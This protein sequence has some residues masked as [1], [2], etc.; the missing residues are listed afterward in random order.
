MERTLEHKAKCVVF[1]LNDTMLLDQLE[2]F[3]ALLRRYEAAGKS[4]YVLNHKGAEVQMALEQVISICSI[5][6]VIMKQSH[7]AYINAAGCKPE[8]FHL[9]FAC[10]EHI[11]LD[12]YSP[13]PR[14]KAGLKV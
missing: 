3:A 11:R 2:P 10:R 1:E 14:E 4:F 9:R 8:V 12:T 13:F 5:P 6:S 7:P